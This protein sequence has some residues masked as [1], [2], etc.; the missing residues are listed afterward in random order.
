MVG[1][2][3]CANGSKCSGDWNNGKLE[4]RGVFIYVNSERYEGM[5]K[6]GL[7]HGAGTILNNGRSIL[8]R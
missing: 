3:Y 8:L 7:R 5:Y 4:G 6:N 2:R 1:T